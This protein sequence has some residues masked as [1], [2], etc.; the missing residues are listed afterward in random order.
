M[1]LADIN[2]RWSLTFGSLACVSIIC[3]ARFIRLIFL[4]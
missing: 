2:S 3:R 4:Y 1:K